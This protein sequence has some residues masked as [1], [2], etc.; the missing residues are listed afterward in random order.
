MDGLPRVTTATLDV[1]EVLLAAPE[2]IWGLR[3]IGAIDRP[4]GSV[5]PI[6]GRLEDRGWLTSSWDEEERRG[7]RRRLYVLTDEAAVAA[8]ALLSE[9]RR[10]ATRSEWS[11]S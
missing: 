3:I 7:P 6:L 11:L 1:L 5:Y 8:R 2:P 9:R 4:A 10:P